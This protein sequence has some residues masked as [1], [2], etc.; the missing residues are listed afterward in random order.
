MGGMFSGCKSLTSLDLSTFDTRNVTNMG[1]MFYGCKS[2]TTL[3]LSSFDTGNVTDM[4]SLFQDCNALTVLDLSSFDTGNVTDMACIFTEC[5]SLERI[6]LG[7]G[8]KW[9][10]WNCYPRAGNWESSSTGKVYSQREIPSGVADAYV[11]KPNTK[12]ST[13]VNATSDPVDDD[14]TAVPAAASTCKAQGESATQKAVEGA[15]P[16]EEKASEES[17]AAAEAEG[18][19]KNGVVKPEV[20][21]EAT[22]EDVSAIVPEGAEKNG[23]VKGGE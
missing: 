10:G 16:L 6:S 2:L 7:T 21:G 8:F 15:P 14:S 11:F 22:K 3:D 23:A 12:A 5:V 13:A 19:E 4:R 9:V 17:S 1:S 20:A 18:A